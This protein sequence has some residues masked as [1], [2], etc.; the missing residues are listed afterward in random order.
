MHTDIVAIITDGASVMK[1][2]GR[3]INID[4]QLCFGHG[5]RL[6]VIEV[7]YKKFVVETAHQYDE[8]KIW[9]DKSDSC[10]EQDTN[11]ETHSTPIAISPMYKLILEAALKF[12]E[13]YYQSTRYSESIL[14]TDPT[15]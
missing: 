7:L 6:G 3:I 8:D 1:E 5:M 13:T 10:Q 11:Y 12:E 2:V 4:Q 9:F 14:V 15:L